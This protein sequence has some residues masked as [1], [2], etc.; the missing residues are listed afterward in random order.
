MIYDNNSDKLR[1]LLHTKPYTKTTHT[2]THTHTQ[3][4]GDNEIDERS[5]INTETLK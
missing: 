1:F 4:L 3:N 2:H 5:K